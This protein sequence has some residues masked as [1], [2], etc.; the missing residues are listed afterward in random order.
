MNKNQANESI[1]II[2]AGS[3]SIKF[4]LYNLSLTLIYHGEIEYLSEKLQITIFNEKNELITKEIITEKDYEAG[5]NYLFSWMENLPVNFHLLA[6]GHRVV[7][8]GCFYDSPILID[9]DS[10]RKLTSLN[11]LAPLHQSYNLAFIKSILKLYPQLPQVACFDTSFHRTQDKIATLFALPRDLTED[12]ILR[13][14]FHGISYEYIASVLPPPIKDK[15]VIVAHLGNGASLCAMKQGKSIATSMGFTALDGLMMGTRCGSIDPG[16]ILYLLQEK[17]YSVN[18]LSDLLYKKSGL[19]GVSGMSSDMRELQSS[20]DINAIEA[21]DLFCYRAAREI[22]ALTSSLH[23]CDAIIFTAGIGE[24]SVPVRKKICDRL[25][26]LGVVLD[27]SANARNSAK[28]SQSHSKI[29]VGVIPTNEGY[30]IAK[31]TLKVVLD[32]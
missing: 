11:T 15:K 16:I 24:H 31:H 29:Y 2:N 17:K 9:K 1:L 7:H 8:G 26:W 5:L 22:C 27:E 23:G 19:L 30:M 6:V 13:Y 25:D 3:S 10:I 28:I 18:E 14:G 20:K 12:G 21:V 32:R 4:S